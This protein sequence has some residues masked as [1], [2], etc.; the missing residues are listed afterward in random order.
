MAL[1]ECWECGGQVSEFASAC[2]RCGAPQGDERPKRC[3]GRWLL[4]LL[5]LVGLAWL[6]FRYAQRQGWIDDE[7]SQRMQAT[8]RQSAERFGRV[9]DP[10]AMVALVRTTEV[11]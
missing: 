8:V 6:L 3:R 9:C 11:V 4:R 1:I 2:P 10:S 5:I 7:A